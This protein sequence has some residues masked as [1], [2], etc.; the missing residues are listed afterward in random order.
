MNR[1]LIAAILPL[2][3]LVFVGIA[4]AEQVYQQKGELVGTLWNP[5]TPHSAYRREAVPHL[6]RVALSSD[7]LV[8]S[9]G[10]LQE[11]EHLLL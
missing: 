1:R 11:F 2:V 10:N 9:Q 3:L 7:L 8:G 6:F 5:Y 4:H